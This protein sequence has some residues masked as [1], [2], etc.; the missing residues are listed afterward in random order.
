MSRNYSGE[1]NR[2]GTA[3][4]RTLSFKNFQ[5]D[6]PNWRCGV[7]KSYPTGRNIR[8]KIEPK[9]SQ[10]RRL[11]LGPH[12]YNIFMTDIPRALGIRLLIVDDTALSNQQQK[13]E[14]NEGS[15]Q[16]QLLVY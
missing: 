10:D 9:K 6:Y 7:T 5:A 11:V 3:T 12:L 15:G 4:C 8:I 16:L 14:C 1:D 13:G 2:D